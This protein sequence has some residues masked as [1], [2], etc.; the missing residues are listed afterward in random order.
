MAEKDII[1]PP[2][3]MI[4]QLNRP[5]HSC[6]YFTELVNRDSVRFREN[7]PIKRGTM[8]GDGTGA[9]Q[10][11]ID[12]F[13]TLFFCKEFV[14]LGSNTVNS[15]Q[16]DSWVIWTW[17]SGFVAES[18]YNAEVNYLG[19]IVANPSFSRS[20]LIRR[21]TYEGSP[22]IAL[23]STLT[24][25]TGVNI[26][27]GGS[28]Y[29]YATGQVGS[30]GRIEFVVS[31]GSLISGIVI[32]DGSGVTTGASITITGDGTGATAT[33]R[34]QPVGAILTS[35][36]KIE[37]E[38]DD[39][40]SH[41]FVRVLRT[42]EVLPGPL[43]P[44]TRWSDLLGPIQGTRRA[45][46]NTSQAPTLTAT[47]KTTYEARNDSGYVSW[48]LIETSSNGTGGAGNPAYPIFTEDIHDNDK[49]EVQRVTQVVVATGSEVSS[50]T[51]VGGVVTH[52]DYLKI[53][54]DAFHLIKLIETWAVPRTLTDQEYDRT[55]DVVYPTQ[56]KREASGTSIGVA[57]AKITAQGDGTDITETFDPTALATA[58]DAYHTYF[59]G[60]I[61][62]DLPLELQSVQVVWE[63]SS[64]DGDS[65]EDSQ[66]QSIGSTWAVQLNQNN[67]AQGSASVMPEIIPTYKPTPRGNELPSEDHFFFLPNPVTSAAVLAKLTA[68]I[69]ASILDWPIFQPDIPTF[70]LR[71]QKVSGQTSASAR[72]SLS[73]SDSGITYLTGDGSGLSQDFG[74]SIGS[75]TL[76]RCIH[77]AISLSG[78][79]EQTA[80]VSMSSHAIAAITFLGVAFNAEGERDET[81]SVEGSVTPTSLT[82]TPGATTV[83]TSGKRMKSCDPNIYGLGYSIIRAQIFDFS[84]LA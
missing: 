46:V 69:G 44:F 33:A 13:D 66:G 47:A 7:S 5:D 50:S 48:Q 60:K 56:R 11:V 4:R 2:E 51:I 67:Q 8:Y 10:T 73:S 53:D 36:K 59:P 17:T 81:L 64:G 38:E 54:G 3:R 28:D 84:V 24:A 34:V 21:D 6:G 61:T 29:T 75:R 70:V 78:D 41:E 63:T 62:A 40:L 76:E 49:G 19:D 26:T 77:G 1:P 72:A 15:M 55:F 37:L 74:S 20:Y 58:L 57:H 35:Q 52:I 23:G 83:P 39:P 65:D 27:N 82:A 32:L 42:Y 16:G 9:D 43:L 71:G 14:P 25:I 30:G 45:V 12:A 31:G 80:E 68:L 79:T 22:T 18:S